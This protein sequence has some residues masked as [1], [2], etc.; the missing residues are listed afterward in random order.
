MTCT[1]LEICPKEQCVYPSD[2][3][4]FVSNIREIMGYC[5]AVDMYFDEEK[6]EEYLLSKIPKGKRRI[7]QQKGWKR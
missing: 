5:P 4:V 2:N 6:Q 3:P 7:G 1:I